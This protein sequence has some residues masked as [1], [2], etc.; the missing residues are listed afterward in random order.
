MAGHSTQIEHHFSPKRRAERAEQASG[1]SNGL[2]V[3][4]QLALSFLKNLSMSRDDLTYL[5]TLKPHHRSMGTHSSTSSLAQT[6]RFISAAPATYA[7]GLANT[8][9]PK[10][11]SLHVIT[12]VGLVYY[13][14]PFEFA[15]ALQRERQLKRWTRAKKLALI[16][17]RSWF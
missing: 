9:D 2:V 6:P 10:Q 11:P 4:G 12:P 14:G 13:E 7:A 16:K 1:I 8:V 15:V 5:P 3:R 17:I